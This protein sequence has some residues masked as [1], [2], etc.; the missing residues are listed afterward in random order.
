MFAHQ[1]TQ[2]NS[3]ELICDSAKKHKKREKLNEI[4]KSEK[5]ERLNEI[6]K[7]VNFYI[8]MKVKFQKARYLKC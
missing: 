5:R 1:M 7:S 6:S 4:S 8:N 2:K 3:A